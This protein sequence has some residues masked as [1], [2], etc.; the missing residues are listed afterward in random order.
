MANVNDVMEDIVCSNS[1]TE[2]RNEKVDQAALPVAPN[3]G[4]STSTTPSAES[5]EDK[6]AK[7]PADRLA[8]EMWK[9]SMENLP[10]ITGPAT[11]DLMKKQLNNFGQFI[12]SVSS[13]QNFCDAVKNTCCERGFP[14]GIA[15]KMQKLANDI[16][17]QEE[18]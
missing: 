14:K 13:K 15:K 16:R 6:F 9:S 1:L 12:N 18:P 17:V 2:N 11:A 7:L 5:L 3:P 8:A 10:G 4:S